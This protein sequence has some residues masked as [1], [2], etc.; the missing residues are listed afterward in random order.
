MQIL[1]NLKQLKNF[2]PKINPIFIK[3]LLGIFLVTILAYTIILPMLITGEKVEKLLQKNITPGYSLKI[4][5]LKTA[6]SLKFNLILRADNLILKENPNIISNFANNEEK[7][8]L[9]AKKITIKI[10]IWSLVFQKGNNFEIISKDLTANIERD[11]NKVFNIQK[12]FKKS[13]KSSKKNFSLKI[14]NYDIKFY[15]YADSPIFLDGRDF[16]LS[17]IGKYKLKN[18]G[19]LSKNNN[20]TILDIDFL[21]KKP[22]NT[23][24]IKLKGNINNFELN[25]YEKYIKEINPN[26]TEFKGT[27]DADFNIDTTKNITNNLNSRINTTDFIISTKKYP[28]FIKIAQNA[29]IV[30]NGSK[31]NHKIYLKKFRIIS[32][33]YNFETS[34]TIKH[35]NRKNKKIN[36]KVKST[37]TSLQELLNIVPKNLSIKYDAVNKMLSANTKGIL[38]TDLKIT[39]QS[40]NPY[41]YGNVSIQNFSIKNNPENSIILANFNKK[42]LHLDV[43]LQ[44][45]NQNRIKILGNNKLGKNAKLNITIN[46]PKI[47]SDFILE[48]LIFLSNTFNFSTGILNELYFSGPIG[49]N[50]QVTGHGENTNIFGEIKFLNTL[51]NYKKLSRG[52]NLKNTSI[53]FDKRKILF[54][55]T[56]FDI[57]SYIG[58]INGYASLDNCLDVTLDLENF[59]T[60]LGLD[61]IKN[62]EL[63]KNI[64]QKLE[65]INFASGAV[66]SKINI[67]KKP[68][69][70]E[71]KE[72]ISGNLIFK[73]SIIGF[74]SLYNY[75]EKLNGEIIFDNENLSSKNLTGSLL[76]GES[77]IDIKISNGQ[78]LAQI[79]TQKASIQESLESLAKS[80]A[81]NNFNKI[82]DG[83]K[84]AGTYDFE[85]L[86]DSAETDIFKSLEVKNLNGNIEN[87]KFPIKI[88]FAKGNFF[89]DKNIFIAKNLPFF[90]LG[91]R[92][93]ITGDIKN[94][95]AKPEYNLDLSFENISGADIQ[96]LKDKGFS[97][98]LEQF[99]NFSG[100][101]R[102]HIKIKD[103]VIGNIL[104]KDF[105]ANYIPYKIPILIKL[106][107]IKIN[108]NKYSCK[109]IPVQ[110]GTSNYKLSCN[111][112][113]HPK[114]EL[115]G[116]LTP[117]DLDYYFNKNLKYPINLRQK[118]PIKVVFSS[119]KNSSEILIGALLK[120]YNFLSYKGTSIG[121]PNNF[122]IIGGGIKHYASGIAFENFGISRYNTMPP[123]DINTIK[124]NKNY[125]KLSGTVNTQQKTQNLHVYAKEFMDINLFNEFL[126]E[127]TLFN[128][129]SFR[130]D[131]GISGTQKTPKLSGYLELSNCKIP[132]YKT[133]IQTLKMLFEQRNIIFSNGHLKI[134]NYNI[135][136]KGI[137]D[138]LATIPYMFKDLEVSIPDLNVDEISKIFVSSSH[139]KSKPKTSKIPDPPL[140]VVKEGNIKANDFELG[141][142]SGSDFKSEF[143]FSRNWILTLQNYS[144]K[145]AGGEVT[146]N[147]KFN[148][149]DSSS[150]TSMKLKNMNANS[151]STTLLQMPNEIYGLLNGDMSMSTKGTSS[152]DI[153]KNM[154]G[155]GRFH[156]TSGRL[157][158][159]GSL[160][161]LLTT[162]EVVKSGFT[163]LSLNN[164]CTVLAAQKTGNFDTI[165]V[166]F[167][168][169]NGVLFTDDLISRSEKLNIYMAGNFDMITN[170]AD[171]TILGKVSKSVVNVL[172]PIG[173]I[174]INKVIT[175]IGGDSLNDYVPGLI[176]MI[177][178]DF[179]NKNFRRFV[180]NIEGNLYDH[181]SVKNFRWID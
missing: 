165:N 59:P 145:S 35:T 126:G 67:S 79:L 80:S 63:T 146:G 70:L 111:E 74:E 45:K 27:L 13:E 95:S 83:N 152:K 104:F 101:A 25:E 128:G 24:K 158:R 50:L 157:V 81:F 64:A 12:A 97:S 127:F 175:T 49:V 140:F 3:T 108:N 61:I 138:N 91:S 46:S 5:N 58:T 92:G 136:F 77:Q 75:L 17:T 53:N 14:K 153:V 137:G 15:D 105:R 87:K 161:Y 48:H 174:S 6:F 178:V 69:Y 71:T 168:I 180:V 171:F 52:I 118:T 170:Y 109:N 26:I 119:D 86:L 117:F 37:N 134:D 39:N 159:M 179:N 72:L 154:N 164:I 36:L 120:N 18:S 96:E 2:L 7:D 176:K 9:N 167:K 32:Q 130:G 166:N 147:S 163:G 150:T 38:T 21:S 144:L 34:G 160:E 121:S 4:D 42:K 51:L 88:N 142:I 43:T 11:K 20:Y 106:G 30:S 82:F 93:N 139:N 55:N 28:N 102:G 135:Y 73:N 47:L 56:K 85:L 1:K 8:I 169:K 23:K 156:I 90:T 177:G 115:E 100:N 84:G 110:I 68:H 113:T 60:L 98:I 173:N 132:A 181:K 124:G 19:L 155:A 29:Q 107:E 112:N 66:T 125:F 122:Y 78:M 62:S 99:N 114:I 131:L 143:S 16:E 123:L 31:K 76:G 94:L 41:I 57:N 148:F 33:K 44:D 149:L 162:A 10:P 65:K 54:S 116:N 141:N 40:K 89:V 133:T 129:G 172:G 22:F 151:V 103:H